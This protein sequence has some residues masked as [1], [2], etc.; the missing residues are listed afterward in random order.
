MGFFKK[1]PAFPE[2]TPTR[3]DE[4]WFR[5]WA[6]DAVGKVGPDSAQTW[7]DERQGE[8]WMLEKANGVIDHDFR[9]YVQRYC[10]PAALK[11][12]GSCFTSGDVT[13]WDLISVTATLQPGKREEW[14]TFLVDDAE[15]KLLRISAIVVDPSIV[16]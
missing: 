8:A 14:E 4:N 15:Q 12:Y 7:Q 1:E 11:M 3:L 13:P 9:D 6:R 16:E 2:P 5:T 10:S